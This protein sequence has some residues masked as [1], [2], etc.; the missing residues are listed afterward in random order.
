M[1][2]RE[3]VYESGINIQTEY[4]IR[5][6]NED[7]NETEIVNESDALDMEILYMYYDKY[8]DKYRNDIV[9]VFEV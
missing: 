6:Y 8:G 4:Q 5:H 3:L 7:K 9:I 2:I 1:T